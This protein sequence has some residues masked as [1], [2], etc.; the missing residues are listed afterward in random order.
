MSY[1][2]VVSMGTVNDGDLCG[3]QWSAYVQSTIQQDM[4]CDD[5]YVWAVNNSNNI[6]NVL[7]CNKNHCCNIYM[8]YG[9]ESSNCLYVYT[10][11]IS[12]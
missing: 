12:K 10:L 3:I 1:L 8:I 2:Y 5:F 7:L 4:V 11:Q 6:W 9:K